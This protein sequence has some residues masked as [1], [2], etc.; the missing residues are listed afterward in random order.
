MD[1]ARL[2]PL[3]AL[4]R[5][6]VKAIPEHPAD[7][8][9]F[10]PGSVVWRVNRDRCF[11]LAGMRSL[12]VQALHPLAMA[13]VAQHS[14]W[15]QDPFGRLAATSSYLLTT[16]YGDTR[17]ALDAAAWVRRVHVHV[18]GTDPETGLPYSAEDPALL[19]WVHAGM[20]DSVVEVVQRYG[21]A[22]DAADADRYVAEMVRF[23]EIVGVPRED[24]PTRVA[25]L[26]R[27]LESVDVRQA[28]PAAREAIAIVL[29]PPG[30]D[31]D[32]R[33]LWH[34]LGQVA[35]GTLPDWARSMYGFG[36][37]PEALMQRE[38]VRQLLGAMDLAFESLPGVVEARQRIE[39]RTRR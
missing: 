27:Y 18:R 38:P 22:L 6:Y 33:D 10:G 2:I 21:R 26:R 15:K 32:T 24:V 5:A 31:H 4:A 14:S 8:G 29:D 11:P 16:T 37:P 25:T 35:V 28:T 34:D 7:D 23:A 20:V 39:L 36:A 12:M 9:L 19:L 17:S 1:T 13:G 3:E 30:L